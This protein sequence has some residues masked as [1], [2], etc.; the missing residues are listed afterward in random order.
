M[1]YQV[2]VALLG[3]SKALKVDESATLTST[4]AADTA[5]GESANLSSTAATGGKCPAGFR[6]G[7]KP[8]FCVPDCPKDMFLN[9][10]G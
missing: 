9:S 7:K 2:L 5:A 4:A 1:K 3:V 8:G 6:D 10:E